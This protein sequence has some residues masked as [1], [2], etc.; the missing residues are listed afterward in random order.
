MALSSSSNYNG[1]VSYNG[2]HYPAGQPLLTADNRGFRYGDGLFET[3]FVQGSRIRLEEYHFDRLLS[4]M[5]LLDFEVP[6]FF[7]K[8]LKEEMRTVCEANGLS[9]TVAARVRLVVFRGESSLSGPPDR[10]P[11]YIIQSW[12]LPAAHEPAG[13]GLAIDIFPDGRKACDVLSNLKS[14]NFLLYILA[15]HYA[16]KQGLDDCLVLNSQNRVADSTI[17]NLFYIRQ[18]Q[19][20]TPPLS[21][22]A[23]AGVMR[24]HLLEALP[25]A[26]YVVHQ[27]PVSPEDLLAADEV[28]LTNAL[29]GI[30]P[31]GAL[32]GR[33]YTNHLSTAVYKQLI[34]SL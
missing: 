12:P 3:M 34:K 4:G 10:F 32:Q 7:A 14:N 26:G 13:S 15:A 28:F 19:F 27:V 1:V 22:G 18:G 5:A 17:A 23:V 21:E 30:R 20:Y 33:R 11:N 2:V 6:P 16:K 9:A 8:K 31:V 25:L 24:R 29:K